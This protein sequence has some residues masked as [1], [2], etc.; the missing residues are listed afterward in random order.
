M[1]AYFPRAIA[2]L[3]IIFNDI[4]ILRY[5]CFVAPLLLNRCYAA[6]LFRSPSSARWNGRHAKIAVPET[7]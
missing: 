6:G 7:T 4:N 5:C 3:I 1:Y 2:D